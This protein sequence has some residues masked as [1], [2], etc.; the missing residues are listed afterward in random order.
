MVVVVVVL[1]TILG[2]DLSHPVPGNAPQ[3]RS[4]NYRLS[5]GRSLNGGAIRN[6]SPKPRS[7]GF[8]RP[9]TMS[10]SGDGSACEKS[11]GLRTGR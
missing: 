1:M 5:T 3:P 6:S 2:D 8:V 7:S 4:P 9:F 10:A 11:E